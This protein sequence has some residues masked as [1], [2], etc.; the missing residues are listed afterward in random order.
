MPCESVARKSA[1]I[2]PP[3]HAALPRMQWALE[4]AKRLEDANRVPG[5]LSAVWTQI[6]CQALCY[7]S[8]LRE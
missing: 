4:D 1:L 8:A 2:K 7:T 5:T 6:K 3:L